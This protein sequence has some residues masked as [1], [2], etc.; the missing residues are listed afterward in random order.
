MFCIIF[1][2]GY[3]VDPR[4]AVSLAGVDVNFR[5]WVDPLPADLFAEHSRGL[6]PPVP[7]R[8]DRWRRFQTLLIKRVR[9]QPV[10]SSENSG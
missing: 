8:F 5:A 3:R 6:S 10:P 4:V 1:Y 7:G 2:F 9:L